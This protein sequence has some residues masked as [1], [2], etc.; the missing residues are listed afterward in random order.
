MT[1]EEWDKD[2]ARCLG[3]FLSGDTLHETDM[4]G[5]PVHDASFLLL[6]NAHHDTIGFRL[7]KIG[8]RGDWFAQ[9]DTAFDTGRPQLGAVPGGSEYPLQGRSLALLRRIDG[10]S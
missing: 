8:E 10:H 4:R 1:E 3:V 2:F 6:F 7:P 9:L 5:R